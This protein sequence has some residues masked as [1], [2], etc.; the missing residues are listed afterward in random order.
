MK[1]KVDLHVHTALSPCGSLDMSPS[2]IVR[3]AKQNGLDVIAVTDH[4]A[5]ENSFYTAELGKKTGLKVIYGVEAQSVEDVHL[6]CYFQERK[7]SEQFHADIY[8]RLPDLKNRT[9][10]FGD[11]VVVDADDNIVRIEPRLL[12]NSLSLSI[13]EIVEIVR[14]YNGIVVPAHVD[15]EKFGL[16]VNMG[17]VPSELQDSVLEVS[18]NR[19][20]GALIASYPELKNHPVMTNSDAHYLWDIGRAF[21]S[22]DIANFSGGQGLLHAIFAEINA[23]RF[24]S[25]RVKKSEQA[26]F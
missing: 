6:L 10:F 1:I 2:A 12:L 14:R 3:Q 18:Y 16:L 21:T 4:N 17:F 24:E 8:P 7:Q 26:V 13:A 22:I 20:P 25:R 11:Q 9:N 19:D 15:S 5:V 23:G